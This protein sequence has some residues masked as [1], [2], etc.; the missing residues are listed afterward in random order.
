M[1]QLTLDEKITLLSGFNF[2]QTPAIDRLG[3]P[4]LFI[5][6]GP[7]GV[8]KQK[9]T[10]GVALDQTEPATCFP[11]ASALAS[12]WDRDLLHKIG[13]AIGIEAR[14]KQVS[15]LL[16]PGVNIKRSP[17]GGR[18]FE[19]Y[20]EDPLLSSQMAAS[21]IQGVQSQGV[22]TSIKHFAANN[23]E[24]RRMTIDTIVD[25]RALREIYLASFET[26]IKV[27]EPW[28]VMSAY[29]AINGVLCSQNTR[30]LNDI[31]RDEWGFR[32]VVVSDWGG[33]YQRVPSLQAGNDLEM[34][35]NGGAHNHV[36]KHAIEHGQLSMDVL[37]QRVERILQLIKASLPALQNPGKYDAKEHHEL[38]RKAAS[39]SAVL[40]KNNDDA[41]PLRAGQSIGVIGAFAKKPRYQGA[42]SSLMAPSRLN[43][44][45]AGICMRFDGKKVPYAAGYGVRDHMPN[46][47]LIAEAVKVARRVE[48]VVLFIGLPDIYETEGVDRPHMRLPDAHNALLDAVVAVNPRVI[49]VLSNGSPVEM[50]WHDKVPAILEGYLGGQAGGSAIADILFGDVNP[51]GKLAETFPVSWQ[52]NPASAY[53][54]GSPQMVEYRES[55][56]VGY[57]YYNTVPEPVLYPFGHGLSYTTF[58][59]DDLQVSATSIS[60]D[61]LL[62]VSMTVTNTGIRAGAE[63]VQLYI[64]DIE[65]TAFRPVHELKGFHK[66]FLQPGE[67][68]KLSFTLNRRTWSFYDVNRSEWVVERGQFE[69]QIGASSRDIRLQAFVE[70][71]GIALT[72]SA[73]QSLM[74]DYYD[75][76]RGNFGPGAFAVLIGQQV[77]AERA[78]KGF[79]T[80][81]TPIADMQDSWLARRFHDRIKREMAAQ[82]TAGDES[83]TSIM[84]RT[85]ADE[86]PLRT[87]LM[88]S[89]GNMSLARLEALLLMINGKWLRGL[90]A[91]WSSR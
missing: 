89:G 26:A 71:R 27:A 81:N 23:Q 34:P 25:E 15:V 19:Y 49:V 35:G 52:D 70:V 2:W 75:L 85:I 69:V 62:V 5:T 18:N 20:S 13:T 10:A 74:A 57:R 17:L 24:Y 90:M 83:P 77:R 1:K 8:R 45:Y 43:T 72:P 14:S 29:N 91:L 55:I 46:E 56:F 37:N 61:E 73:Q 11:T 68:R 4:S 32:G 82:F 66:V 44:A 33:I 51:S 87:L 54:P 40:L 6:D 53:F 78:Q 22:G 58:A 30:L 88:F 28:T 60:P 3:I 9:Q 63:V 41:L 86:M 42:G 84:F 76:Q 47:S 39:Q 16:G 64:R 79:Y 12:S 59:Y 7:H 67:S 31:L 21:F 36:I 50:P 38:A 65:S 48:T 80:L